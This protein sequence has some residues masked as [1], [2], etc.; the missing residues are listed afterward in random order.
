MTSL[1]LTALCFLNTS[2]AASLL[3]AA[4]N[5]SHE[6]PETKDTIVKVSEA[7]DP[8]IQTDLLSLVADTAEVPADLPSS[9][10]LFGKFF[11][12]RAEFFIIESPSNTLYQSGIHSITLFHLDGRLQQTKY[13][14]E[15]NIESKLLQHLG[16]C[17]IIPL[18][19][20][21][22]VVAASQKIVTSEKGELVL[23]PLLT[24]YELKWI[25]EDKLIRYRVR[26]DQTKE[27]FTYI[28]SSKNYEQEMKEIE[29]AA[30]F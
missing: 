15:E 10:H 13:V 29:R 20:I 30:I 21:S 5:S 11:N 8:Y 28:E 25:D 22:K 6:Q 27:T 19:S 3:L 14:V 23:N 17:K 7:R 2:V 1:R 9:E 18:D 26:R 4:C 24:H 16:P 12:D